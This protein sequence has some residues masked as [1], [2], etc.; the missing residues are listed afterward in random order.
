MKQIICI[1]FVFFNFCLF[2]LSISGQPTK[3]ALIFAIGNYPPTGG[4]PMIS[5]IA[6]VGYV[7]GALLKQGF[8][9]DNIKIYKDSEVTPQSIDKAF[10][11]LEQKTKQGDIVL[12]Y[13][14]THGEKIEDDNGDEVD[15][16]DESIVT[17]N[18]IAPDLDGH[19]ID[20]NVAQKEYIRDDKIG[21]YVETL[22]TLLGKNGDL[23]IFMDLCYSGTAIRGNKVRGGKPPLVSNSFVRKKI[24]EKD[25]IAAVFDKKINQR[26]KNDQSSPYVFISA[27]RADE[28]DQETT[29]DNNKFVGSLTYSFTKAL[30]NSNKNS[31]YRS[32]FSNIQAIMN[33]KV[34][35]QHPTIEGNG[36]D[37]T[38]FGGNFVTQKPYVEID[39]ISGRQITLKSGLVEGLDAGML[40]YIYDVNT[41]DPLKSKALDSA[42]ILKSTLYQSEAVL[43][44]GLKF[45]Q[46]S[47]GRVFVTNSTYI[48]KSLNLSFVGFSADE[49]K[50]IKRGLS[51]I[52]LLNFEDKPDLILIH[53]TIADSV[54]I[55]SNYYLFDTLK[56]AARN[57]PELLQKIQR[58]VQ[59]RFLQNLSIVDPQSHLDV[60]LVPWVNGIADINAADH[61]KPIAEFKVGNKFILWVKNT[62][63]RAC[64]F[65]I[66]DLQPDGIINPVLPNSRPSKGDPIDVNDLRIEADSSHL[67]DKYILT[68]APPCG[69]EI[70]KIFVSTKP[71]DL[72][73]IANSKGAR[74]NFSVLEKLVKNSY[75]ITKRG[76]PGV[77]NLEE[78][79]GS[80]YN[81]LFKIVQ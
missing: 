25:N 17:Y 68:V 24:S 77:E 64:Y 44:N 55:A 21:V 60:K 23:D 50:S 36:I 48:V 39:K 35:G 38:L 49:T 79:N 15:G 76:T 28:P 37:R 1:A 52:T 29:D 80:A 66:L 26:D 18:A 8:S 30:Q 72:E 9:D 65:N 69:L 74:G 40:V 16:L 10:K 47:L 41:T 43:V 22:R 45:T 53:G 73:I 57:F 75:G 31:T 51:N 27:S 78:A 12:I 33:D 3:H 70:Y 46:P 58:Y 62:G 5:S 6:D 2:S 56:D 19:I 54:V 67:F 81:L 20:F 34:P 11:D 13:F 4:W 63:S 42:K 71:I 7:R 59:Y 14:S 61:S 32:L